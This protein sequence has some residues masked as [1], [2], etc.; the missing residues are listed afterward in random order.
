MRNHFTGL[1][2]AALLAVAPAFPG[3]AEDAAQAK[4]TRGADVADVGCGHGASTV[5]LAQAYPASNIVGFDADQGS[6]DAAR[7]RAASGHRAENR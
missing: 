7:K 5:L 3:H 2:I 6:V 1:A 4:L